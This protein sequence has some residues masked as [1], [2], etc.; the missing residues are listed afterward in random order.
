MNGKI[1]IRENKF[2]DGILISTTNTNDDGSIQELNNDEIKELIQ[3]LSEYVD[4]YPVTSENIRTS[5]KNKLI[6]DFDKEIK[7]NLMDKFFETNEPFNSEYIN[8]NT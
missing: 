1:T 3:K 4:K 2:G 6:E 8:S 5:K 7:I